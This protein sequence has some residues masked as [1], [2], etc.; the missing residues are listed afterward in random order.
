V[1]YAIA[2]ACLSAL[3]FASRAETGPATSVAAP[4]LPRA[5]W[6]VTNSIPATNEIT[7]A[8]F[9]NEV[10]AANLDYAAQRYNVSIAQTAIAAAKEFQNPTLQLLGGRDV[11][12]SGSERMPSI[13]GV[14]LTQTLELGGKRKYR[15]RGAQQNYAA[16]AATLDDFLRNLK[17][18]AAAAFADALALSRN[19]EQ[20]RQSAEYLA[21]L[22][23][24]QRAR[25]RAGD[26][27]QADLLQTQVEERQFE[28]E[29]L[30]ARADAE[31]ASLALS[32]FLGRNRGR[33]LLIPKGKLELPGR[34]FD[35]ARL[36]A[37]ALRN[38]SDLIAL[39]HT[40]DAAQ[41]AVLQEK[42]NRIPSVDVGA[43]WTHNTSSDNS[44]APAPE[45]DSV[46]LS[47]S[48]PIP[49][50]N[51]NRAAIAAAR[52]A[53]DRAQKQVEAAELKAEVQIRRAFTSYGSA[54]ERVRQYQGGILKDADAVL[55]AKRFSYQRGQAT[56]LELLEAQRAAND[57]RASYN[58]ALADQARTL[59]ELERAAQLWEIEF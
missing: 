18:D 45:F 13:Y 20:K 28:N 8:E 48:F 12:D 15:V 3:G 6:S 36:L 51:R 14:S 5:A 21:T 50:W 40:R 7:F 34:E 53:A 44:I 37:G 22:A 46:G 52:F 49:L 4:C 42:A 58:D 19:A 17:L 54:V 9:L 2:I 56:L 27:S 31:S 24:R 41:S 39:R 1:K 43:G 30:A 47:L 10:A 32:G 35:L 59:V 16:T 33:T 55:E 11:T 29:S 26:I 38:R 25:Y 23:D 57:V